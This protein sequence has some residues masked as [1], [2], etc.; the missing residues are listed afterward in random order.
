MIGK[1]KIRRK[2]RLVGILPSS[3]LVF[4]VCF[5]LTPCL[6]VGHVH[7]IFVVCVQMQADVLDLR[8]VNF[9]FIVLNLNIIISL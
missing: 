9:Y 7:F 3:T 8:F 1:I 2:C 5:F 6:C 4:F